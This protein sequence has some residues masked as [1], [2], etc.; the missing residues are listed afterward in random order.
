MIEFVS[1]GS[2]KRNGDLILLKNS[3]LDDVREKI[4]VPNNERKFLWEISFEKKKKENFPFFMNVVQVDDN[5]SHIKLIR[6]R[7][8]RLS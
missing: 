7:R 4:Y 1:K 2:F 8:T 6:M 3:W 5:E